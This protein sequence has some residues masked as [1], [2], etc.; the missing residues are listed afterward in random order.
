MSKISVEPDALRRI[1]KRL[2]DQVDALSAVTVTTSTGGGGTLDDLTDV[3]TTTPLTGDVLT[4]DGT[5]W[6]NLPPGGSPPI[7]AVSV[8]LDFGTDSTYASREVIGQSWVTSNM[9]FA[10][11]VAGDTKTDHDPEDGLLEELSFTVSD[12]VA[13]VGFTLHGYA[14][15]GTF[16]KFNVHVSGSVSSGSVVTI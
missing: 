2:S 4:Y 13:G 16:G 12:I 8:E 1:L 15:N 9:V 11:M 6:V 10:T 7:T 3:T 5:G 14:P